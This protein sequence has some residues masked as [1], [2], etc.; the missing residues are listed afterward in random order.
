MLLVLL[1]G[2]LA[3]RG[4]GNRDQSGRLRRLAARLHDLF[5]IDTNLRQKP[6]DGW[7]DASS[8][9][10]LEDAEEC[11]HRQLRELGENVAVCPIRTRTTRHLDEADLLDVAQALTDRLRGRND[12]LAGGFA[13]SR[14]DRGQP[15][16]DEEESPCVVELFESRSLLESTFRF[17]QKLGLGTGSF[18]Q[19]SGFRTGGLSEKLGPFTSGFRFLLRLKCGGGGLTAFRCGDY[20]GLLALTFLLGLEA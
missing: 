2:S 12:D 1:P 5:N 15:F 19:K 17:G 16:H 7:H 4:S 6:A 20:S 11:L 13:E 9:E 8:I 3:G 14:D 18:S 10:L